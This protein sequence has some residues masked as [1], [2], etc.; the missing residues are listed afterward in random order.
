MFR[1]V[2]ITP[3]VIVNEADD[4]CDISFKEDGDGKLGFVSARDDLV[5]EKAYIDLKPEEKEEKHRSTTQ[6]EQK[7]ANVIDPRNDILNKEKDS[8]SDGSKFMASVRI[9]Y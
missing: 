1:L 4:N 2:E 6:D 9:R 8:K 7:V 3:Y 5:I